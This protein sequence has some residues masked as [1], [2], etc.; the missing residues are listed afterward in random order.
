[1][2]FIFALSSLFGDWTPCKRYLLLNS[3]QY[4]L[5]QSKHNDRQIILTADHLYIYHCIIIRVVL[6][7]ALSIMYIMYYVTFN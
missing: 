6:Y 3:W 1:M 4:G 5:F 2:K 7:D